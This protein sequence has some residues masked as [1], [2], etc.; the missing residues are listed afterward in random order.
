MSECSLL[1][2]PDADFGWEHLPVFLNGE[3]HYRHVVPCGDLK[4]HQLDPVCW[5][6]PVIEDGIVIHNAADRRE[7]YEQGKL[8]S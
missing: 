4:R 6:T 8:M 7:D 5:C 1:H 2:E 3:I